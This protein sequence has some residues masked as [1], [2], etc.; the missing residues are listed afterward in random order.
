MFP[1]KDLLQTFAPQTPVPH[2][3]TISAHIAPD[4]FILWEEYEKE[5]QQITEI[6]YWAAVWPGAKS[7]ASYILKNPSLVNGKKILD[8]GS[9]S[10]V[11]SIAAS[12]AGALSVIANDIDPVAQHIANQNFSANDVDVITSTDNLLTSDKNDYFDLILVCDMFY[13]R[14]TAAS[15]YNFLFRQKNSGAQIIIA[16]GTRPFTPREDLEPLLTETLPVNHTLEGMTH[17]TVTLFRML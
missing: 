12:R 9:G 15:T 3:E 17:R 2:C 10:G 8:F 7:L 1:S 14:S 16:D 5:Q 11:V 6:P 4:F 13:E